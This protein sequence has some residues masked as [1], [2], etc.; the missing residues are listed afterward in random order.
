MSLPV[1][2]VFLF[3]QDNEEGAWERQYND[4]G[5][6]NTGKMGSKAK[7]YSIDHVS[8][9]L[10]VWKTWSLERIRLES[11]KSGNVDYRWNQLLMF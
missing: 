6:I 11:Q 3:V 4:N 5:D 7:N 2:I 9:I 10:K 8:F 1:N